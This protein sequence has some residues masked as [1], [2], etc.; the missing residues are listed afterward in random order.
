M[1]QGGARFEKTEIVI[2]TAGNNRITMDVEI[3]R[4]QKQHSQGL[5]YRR[6]LAD[7]AGM[8][9]IF[10]RDQILSFWMKNTSIPL[11]IAFIS[12]EGVII[13]TRDMEPFNLA[14]IHSSR[15]ARFALEVPRSWF[16]RA[17][18]GPGDRIAGT[19]ELLRN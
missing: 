15:S 16:A 1:P 18:I 13:E 11:S 5:M 12:A 10:E 7:G 14:P 6:S 17:G 4:D 9:F 8:L 19:R 3:A 2:E